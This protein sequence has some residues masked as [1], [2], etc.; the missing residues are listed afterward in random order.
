MNL[1]LHPFR[2]PLKEPFVLSH[3]T[4]HHRETLIIELE[5]GPLK[6]YGEAT[7]ITYYGKSMAD[8]TKKVHEQKDA[9]QSLELDLSSPTPPRVPEIFQEEPFLQSALDCAIWDL[10]GQKN[11]TPIHTFLSPGQEPPMSSY[12][13]S[14]SPG[15]ISN[16]L[17]K[18]EWPIY[19]VKLGSVEDDAILPILFSFSEEKEIRIDANGGWSPKQAL[20]Y[21]KELV[22]HNI[23]FIEQPLSTD[24][25][26]QI[27]A[28]KAATGAQFWA[29]ESAQSG[30][31]ITHCSR[32]FDG[33]NFK[34]MKSG[35]I[36]PVLREI[37]VAREKGLKIG[38]GCM[39]ETS[40]GIS[41]LGQIAALSDSLDMDGNL[42][43][44]RDPGKGAF[45]R[46][47]KVVLPK[48]NGLGCSWR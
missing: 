36:S 26:E 40:F 18:G 13:L 15:A 31:S 19:K 47:G 17:Q 46:D 30:H 14:G 3:G 25:D 8:L 28:L 22:A 42:L 7:V 23:T 2:L 20:R 44:A 48:G 29:D 10:W 21:I 39:T 45:I 32:Y 1:H 41:A 9:I 6:G 37:E 4:F 27:P 5:E 24:L 38:L 43:L 34:L 11:N 16:T 35:G 33:I 12:T